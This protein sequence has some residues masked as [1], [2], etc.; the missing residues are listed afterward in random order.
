[1]K[2]KLSNHFLFWLLTLIVF[3][4]V[5][6]AISLKEGMVLD[7][8]AY[9]AISRNLARSAG[10]FWAPRY[11]ATVHP[12]F[13]EHP[14]L[15]FGI[16]SLFFKVLGESLFVER[17]YTILTALIT[18]V[19]IVVIWRMIFQYDRELRRY[20]WLPLLL[21]LIFPINAWAYSNNLLENTMGIF[22]L[23]AIALMVKDL[24]KNSY[25]F[26]IGSGVMIFLAVFSKGPAAFFPAAFYLIA[27]IVFR[28]MYGRRVL[29]NSLIIIF[30]PVALFS[31]LLLYP[32]AREN[33]TRYISYQIIPSLKGD[34]LFEGKTRRF[35]ILN[36]LFIYTLP[37]TVI[38]TGLL[39]YGAKRK[40]LYLLQGDISR[41]SVFLI[42]TGFSA[43]LP[44]IISPKQNYNY[45]IPALPY[46]TL[47]FG[48]LI[49][50]IIDS[51]LGRIRWR[52]RVLRITAAS[53][54]IILLSSLIYSG[55]RTDEVKSPLLI[56]YK[57]SIFPKLIREWVFPY[58]AGRDRREEPPGGI[59]AI[60]YSH[61]WRTI[62][63]GDD[64]IN[65]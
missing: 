1:V 30:I 60:R 58:A 27:W 55:C 18:G 22:T 5:F 31:L 51:L 36:I 45:L 43:S 3:S 13:F 4:L 42:L 10:S 44:M 46:F 59:F 41:W 38:S 57:Y 7:G 28:K 6:L 40:R 65:S 24:K 20:S 19:L 54:G 14:P 52:A 48:V 56:N 2:I 16:Q 34:L 17:F 21:W 49:V 39:I 8:T 9:S 33:F 62:T 50:P 11:T 63:T 32:P 37:M 35:F 25:L 61:D 12:A 15:V 26:A 53:L 23:A 64:N 47:G 29:A